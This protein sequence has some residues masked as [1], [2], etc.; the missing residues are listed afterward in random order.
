MKSYKQEIG[1]NDIS[2]NKKDI[3]VSKVFTYKFHLHIMHIWTGS[4]MLRHEMP[5]PHYVTG[6][7]IFNK[8]FPI[9]MISVNALYMDTDGVMIF[10]HKAIQIEIM[11]RHFWYNPM[12]LIYHDVYKFLGVGFDHGLPCRVKNM[13]QGTQ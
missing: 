10:V 8:N 9:Q 11:L 12:S 7:A 1:T 13:A 6:R 5:V 4:P 3:H 2:Y